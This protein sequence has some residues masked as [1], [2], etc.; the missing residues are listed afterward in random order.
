MWLSCDFFWF[1]GEKDWA[2]YETA[3]RLKGHVDKIRAQYK[4][5]LKAKEMWIRQRLES[6]TS[7]L[8]YS[9]S[10]LPCPRAVAVYFIDKLAL[11]AGNE[12]D[13]DESAD[14][15][16]CCSLRVEHIS[17]W[18]PPPYKHTFPSLLQLKPLNYYP[19]IEPSSLSV[20]PSTSRGVGWERKCDRVWLSWEGFYSILQ[21]CS[22]RQ[23][24]FQE[25]PSFHE[26]QKWRRWSLW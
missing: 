15:V 10:S 24:S 22:C 7:F 5:D 21:S 11:R 19:L 12:K 26:R 1:Q 2:K 13:S 3:R 8:Q 17:K 25:C 20:T 23:T 4:E 6:A 14:T 9:W 16:G 18:I